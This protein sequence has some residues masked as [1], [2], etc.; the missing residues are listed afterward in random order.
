[1]DTPQNEKRKKEIHGNLN[2]KRKAPL[3]FISL[4]L[5]PKIVYNKKD[6]YGHSF[7]YQGDLRGIETDRQ[8]YKEFM[9]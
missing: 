6:R 4:P 2:V 1:M 5:A 3:Y 7:S 9:G 8:G